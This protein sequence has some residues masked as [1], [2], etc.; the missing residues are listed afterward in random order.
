MP[1]LIL[2]VLVAQ[3]GKPPDMPLP[4]LAASDVTYDLT[5]RDIHEA[6]AITKDCRVLEKAR[7]LKLPALHPVQMD[8]TYSCASTR[9]KVMSSITMKTTVGQPEDRFA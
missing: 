1:G 8:W 4:A 5:D 2:N 6:E 7:Y 3:L 9:P